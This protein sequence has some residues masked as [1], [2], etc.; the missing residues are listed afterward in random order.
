MATV[1]VIFTRRHHIGSLVLRGFLWSHWSHCAIVDGS[2]V[3]E[4]AFGYPVRARPLDDLLSESSDQDIIYIEVP[5]AHARDAVI[6]AARAEIGKPYDWRG[7]VGFLPRADIHDA[8]AWFC[9]ELV[10]HAFEAACVPLF[11]C[12]PH[13]VTP[14]MIYT[15]R[16]G[17][18]ARG[19]AQ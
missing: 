13:R 11:R 6:A 4:A 7:V 17:K 14:P 1:P 16:F 19:S 2:E 12:R 9:S 10:A 8:H 15:P 3:I 5:D 18:L